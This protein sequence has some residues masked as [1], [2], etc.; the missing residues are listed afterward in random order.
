MAINNEPGDSATMDFLRTQHQMYGVLD[1]WRELGKPHGRLSPPMVD[2]IAADPITWELYK[3]D[4]GICGTFEG[5]PRRM[6]VCLG[7]EHGAD[8]C[9]QPPSLTELKAN[10]VSKAAESPEI[11]L[12]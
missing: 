10:Y 9:P 12:G 8:P 7:D 6:F 11:W 3:A 1:K 5:E 2:A 4:R